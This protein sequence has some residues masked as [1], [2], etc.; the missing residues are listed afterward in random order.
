MIAKLATKKISDKEIDKLM[1]IINEMGHCAKE[2]D[3]LAYNDLDIQFHDFILNISRNGRLKE[4]Y[5]NLILHAQRFRI[6]TKNS[7]NITQELDLSKILISWDSGA[8]ISRVFLDSK[9]PIVITNSRAR[10]FVTDKL[11]ER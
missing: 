1:E 4:I 8:T 9:L 7:E 11:I 5:N 2:D 6:R 3:R 10:M